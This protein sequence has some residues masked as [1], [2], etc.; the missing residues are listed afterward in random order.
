[1]YKRENKLCHCSTFVCVSGLKVQSE[2]KTLCTGQTGDH[3]HNLRLPEPL[4]DAQ[5][6][7]ISKIKRGCNE[8][9]MWKW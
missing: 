9:D 2:E 8:P 7:Y 1:M 3:T 5:Y 4:Q 6:H